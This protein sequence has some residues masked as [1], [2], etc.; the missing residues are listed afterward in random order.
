MP[1]L[2]PSFSRPLGIS[3]GRK[4]SEHWAKS[5]PFIVSQ[6]YLPCSRTYSV[7]GHGGGGVL[8]VLMPAEVA[9]SGALP[10]SCVLAA[11]GSQLPPSL[12][13]CP[14]LNRNHLIR[15]VSPIFPSNQ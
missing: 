9:V 11:I 10:S 15:E 12:E 1:V 3:Y 2:Y 14:Q 5:H 7:W 13:N 6:S 4:P 8:K